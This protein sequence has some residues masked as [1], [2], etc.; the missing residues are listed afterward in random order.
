[1]TEAAGP[2]GPGHETPTA[3]EVGEQARRLRS[4]PADQVIADALFSLLGAAQ[5]KLGRRDARLLIDV[6]T[7]AHQHARSYLPD[8]LTVQI[9]Q[10]LG[11]LRLDQVSAEG[12]ASGQGEPEEND[13]DKVPAPPAARPA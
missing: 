2:G 9:D 1:M 11:Q 10:I 7:V 5:V 13:L 8:Q 3:A 6:T 12:H 4:F